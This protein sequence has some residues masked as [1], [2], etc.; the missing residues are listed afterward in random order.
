MAYYIRLGS[1]NRLIIPNQIYELFEPEFFKLEWSD[2]GLVLKQVKE[3]P[4]DVPED[5]ITEAE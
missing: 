4:T 1:K 3:I 2:S 5:H